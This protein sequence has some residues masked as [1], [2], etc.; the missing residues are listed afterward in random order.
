[1]R[2]LPD[3]WHGLTDVDTRFRQRYVDLIANDDARRVFE[4][5]FAAIAAM[6]RFLARA[7]LR[8]GR[9]AGARTPIAGGAAAQPFVTH[10]NALDMDLSL[11]IAL[12]L[13]L[14]R[15]L[16][17]GMEK[18]FEIGRVF[19]NEGLSTRHNPEFTMLE[20]YEAFAD[21]TRHDDAHRGARR[22]VRVGRDR[23][24]DRCG[25]WRDR[26]ARRRRGRG[27]TMIELDREHAGVDV[28]PAMPVAE[29]AKR[30]RRPRRAVRAGLGSRQAGARDVREDRRAEA[31]RAGV[32]DRLSARGLAART[33]AP[34]RSRARRAVRAR[35]ARA[36]ARPTRSA[37][38]TTRRP[39]RAGSRPRP[40]S[41]LPATRKPTS[42][43]EDYVRALEYGLPPCGGLGIGDRPAGDA[44]RGRIVDPGSDLLS[45]PRAEAGCGFEEDGCDPRAGHRDGRR[46][47]HAGRPA[48]R[49]ALR[50][51]RDRRRRLRAAPPAVA[52]L[53]VPPHRSSRS[54]RARRLRARVRARLPS[55]TSASTSRTHGLG[56]RDAADATSVGTVA[57]L[58][59]AARAGTLNCVVLRRVSTCTGR[60]RGRPAMPDESRP[61]APTTPYGRTCFEVEAVA[62]GLG[63]RL[64]SPCA[65]LR[66][67]AGRRARMCRARWVGCLRLPAVPVPRSPTRRSR[68]CTRTMRL[69]R[70][71][72][73]SCRGYDGPLNI[74]GPGA[75]SPWQAVRL[76]GRVP[77]PVLGPSWAGGVS[78]APSSQARRCRRTCSS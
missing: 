8:R 33:F 78:R 46:A 9:D 13:H 43:D 12:E 19:R 27:A 41:P 35:R 62:A 20:L 66:Y 24:D 23:H 60:G 17:G 5:R 69:A 1:M 65:S 2:P 48:A 45:A 31:R 54:R 44:A 11:R 70:W 73:P 30:L 15:L 3:K 76:G 22:R 75:A 29:A 64:A 40:R 67:G 26:R 37:S 7:R 53:R 6:R 68:S 14:K 16:V 61:P 77:V 42:V 39:A 18:V 21:Y 58:G 50:R 4:I 34:R 28:H 52:S 72:R 25:R 55:R 74:V 47:G 56:R 63:R 10:H 71:S 59:A 32:R 57:A 51:R 49:G 38:S 36:R